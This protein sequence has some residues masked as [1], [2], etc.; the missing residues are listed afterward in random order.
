MKIGVSPGLAEAFPELEEVEHNLYTPYDV[1]LV[2]ASE[3]EDKWLRR[4][5]RMLRPFFVADVE[6]A[7]KIF[8]SL[9]PKPIKKRKPRK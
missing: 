5:F 3:R 8:D 1:T 7:K 2:L 4:R 6:S 9:Q